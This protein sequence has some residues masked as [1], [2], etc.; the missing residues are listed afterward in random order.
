M[1][2]QDTP[3]DDLGAGKPTSSE[4]DPEPGFDGGGPMPAYDDNP[5]WGDEEAA[6]DPDAPQPAGREGRPYGVY[7]PRPE[8]ERDRQER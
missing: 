5:K 3:R 2:R 7:D 8:D 4:D 6:L 1:G